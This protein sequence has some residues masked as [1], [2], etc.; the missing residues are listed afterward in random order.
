VPVGVHEH[1]VGEPRLVPRANHLEPEFLLGDLPQLLRVHARGRVPTF[2]EGFDAW[3][4]ITD[5]SDSDCSIHS[6]LALAY[7][8]QRSYP[9]LLHISG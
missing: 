5:D 2:H 7:L 1:R 4:L 8:T 6:F 3:R 9:Q